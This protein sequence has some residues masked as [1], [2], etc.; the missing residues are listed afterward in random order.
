MGLL[1]LGIFGEEATLQEILILATLSQIA[2]I[3]I[4][5]GILCMDSVPTIPCTHPHPTSSIPISSIPFSASRRK[6]QTVNPIIQ[7]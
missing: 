3:W 1:D 4:F 2:G 6:Q 7:T 5:Q